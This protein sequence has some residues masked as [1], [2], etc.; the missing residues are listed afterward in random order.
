M[1]DSKKYYLW[2]DNVKGLAI[3]LVMLH[4]CNYLNGKENLQWFQHAVP[5]FLFC[6]AFL[7]RNAD[8]NNYFSRRRLLRLY[9]RIIR[10]YF[11]AELFVLTIIAILC[12]L[13][14]DVFP[15]SFSHLLRFAGVGPGSYFPILYV[16]CWCV[17]PFLIVLKRHLTFSGSF[18]LFFFLCLIL[19]TLFYVLDGQRVWLWR[20]L[21]VRYLMILYVGVFYEEFIKRKQLA[22]VLIV[23]SVVLAVV[24][25]YFYPFDNLGWNGTHCF[26][27]FY[28]L[29][30]IP[31]LQKL[32]INWLAIVG[33]YSYEIFLLQMS[34]LAIMNYIS[35]YNYFQNIFYI[36]ELNLLAISIIS[37]VYIQIYKKFRFSY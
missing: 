28:I 3:I 36:D 22:A 21:A 35:R 12:L 26:T 24:D 27:S 7:L 32:C 4:H 23:L 15:Y 11:L 2:I 29:L 1:T 10:P 37:L 17:I 33:K 8:I 30:L 5:L 25:I 18:V 16:Q 9:S 13:R 31:F 20:L 6:S 14:K 34:Y 19:E